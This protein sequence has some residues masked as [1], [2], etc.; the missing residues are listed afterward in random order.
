MVGLN[1]RLDTNEE[2]NTN[3]NKLK[4]FSEFS[5]KR[6]RHGKYERDIKEA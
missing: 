1:R 2:K 4:H 6:Q 5:S 3:K